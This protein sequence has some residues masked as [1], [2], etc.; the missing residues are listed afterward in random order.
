MNQLFSGYAFYCA[1]FVV[2]PSLD[3]HVSGLEFI[4][5]VSMPRNRH[6]YVYVPS[7]SAARG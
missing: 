3:I 2:L 4:C 1:F 5:I 6:T 7:P